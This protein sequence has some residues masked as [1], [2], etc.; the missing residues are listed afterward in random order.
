MSVSSVHHKWIQIKSVFILLP[1]WTKCVVKS[2]WVDCS[3]S[4]G[5]FWYWLQLN[6]FIH[7]CVICQFL[8]LTF[9]YNPTQSVIFTLC[10]KVLVWTSLGLIVL[11]NHIFLFSGRNCDT[12]DWRMLIKMKYPR[13]MKSGMRTIYSSRLNKVFGSIFQG[14]LMW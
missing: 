12:I 10:I 14:Y 2:T 7:H 11:K 5:V 3:Q 1:F 8:S 6:S 9:Q 13:N 4:W